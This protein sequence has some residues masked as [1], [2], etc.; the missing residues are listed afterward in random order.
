[1][2]RVSTQVEYGTFGHEEPVAAK[3]YIPNG[4]YLVPRKRERKDEKIQK[5]GI[6]KAREHKDKEC[7][8]VEYQQ[9]ILVVLWY[10]EKAQS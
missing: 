5:R 7:R 1:M 2:C 3:T 8:N 10:F 6:A 4:V 9:F